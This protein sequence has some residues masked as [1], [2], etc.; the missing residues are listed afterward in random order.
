[1]LK[2]SGE[3]LLVPMVMVP[4]NETWVPS[5][6]ASLERGFTDAREGRLSIIDIASIFRFADSIPDDVEE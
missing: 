4:E 3:I 2:P 5:A 1:M 6:K